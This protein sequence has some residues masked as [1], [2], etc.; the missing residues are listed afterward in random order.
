MANA[1]VNTVL[2]EKPTKVLS[3]IKDIKWFL[4]TISV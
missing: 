4:E 3:R 1:K 2:E